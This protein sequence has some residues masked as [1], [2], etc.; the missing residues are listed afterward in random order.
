M[1]KTNQD[2]E[3]TI[4]FQEKLIMVQEKL[5]ENLERQNQELRSK[6]SIKMAVKQTSVR[7][8]ISSQ[9]KQTLDE[10]GNYKS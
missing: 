6:M 7:N 9:I 1:E 5:I 3:K 10:K 2:Y 4:D 8:L